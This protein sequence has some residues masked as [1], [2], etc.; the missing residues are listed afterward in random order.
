[1]VVGGLRTKQHG[2]RLTPCGLGDTD[3]TCFGI[4][5]LRKYRTLIVLLS[6]HPYLLRLNFASTLFRATGSLQP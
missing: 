3:Q 2:G 4:L 5:P 1:V 6:I